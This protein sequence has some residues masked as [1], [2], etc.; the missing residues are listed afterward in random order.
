MCFPMHRL[1]ILCVCWT[2]DRD[3]LCLT[4]ALVYSIISEEKSF[5]SFPWALLPWQMYI[6]HGIFRTLDDDTSESVYVLSYMHEGKSAIFDDVQ[7]AGLSP[8]SSSMSVSAHVELR[9]KLMF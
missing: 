2:G 3:H 1:T 4:G 9:K 7:P 8:V 6:Q 5:F